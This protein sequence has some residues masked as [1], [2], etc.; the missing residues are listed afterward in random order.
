VLAARGSPRAELGPHGQ[1]HLRRPAG[2]ERQLGRLV[3]QLV[4]AHPQEVEVHQLDDRAH[5]GHGRPHADAHD[6]RLGDRRVAHPRAEPVGQ[7]AGEPE[8]VAARAHVDAG[9]E[10]PVVRLQLGLQC[11]ADG[12]H[13]AEHRGVLGG[14]RRLGKRRARAHHE[15]VHG[16]CVRGV[17]PPGRLDRPV[18]LAC[19][20][21]LQRL[22]LV[23]AHP[24]LAQ[25]ALVRQERVARL[26]LPYLLG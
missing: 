7:P 13:G 25:P 15:V 22:D 17:E 6:R 26:P 8:D 2:H 20:R 4:E 5:P 14:R 23:V 3:E 18:E 19:D 10:H 24:R 1:P 9:H 11:G 21:R 12:V 16:G